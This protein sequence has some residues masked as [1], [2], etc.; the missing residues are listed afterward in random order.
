MCNILQYINIYQYLLL[1]IRE[2][3]NSVDFNFGTS[4]FAEILKKDSFRFVNLIHLYTNTDIYI[5]N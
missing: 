1:L 3:S 2:P 4:R 5:L